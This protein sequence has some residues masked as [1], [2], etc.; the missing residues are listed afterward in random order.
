M[1]ARSYRFVLPLEVLFMTCGLGGAQEKAA[2]LVTPSTVDRATMV[3]DV[4]RQLALRFD[5]ERPIDASLKDVVDDIHGRLGVNFQIDAVAF[6]NTEPPL[7]N[8]EETR[9]KITRT[10]N[11]RL[12]Q[13]LEQ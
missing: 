1:S 8:V 9:I 11:I 5:V 6:K 2:P 7:E 10:K 12:D 3:D 4:I 13:F